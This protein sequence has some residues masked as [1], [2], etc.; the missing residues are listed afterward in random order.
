M[1]DNFQKLKFKLLKLNLKQ[2]W[3]LPN[4]MWN[5]EIPHDYMYEDT[6]LQLSFVFNT[7]TQDELLQLIKLTNDETVEGI[8]KNILIEINNYIKSCVNFINYEIN[9]ETEKYFQKFKKNSCF[10]YE[11]KIKTYLNSIHL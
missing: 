5:E 11:K 2:D 4:E 9:G 7:F 6:Y 1:I 8:N 3:T 10:S